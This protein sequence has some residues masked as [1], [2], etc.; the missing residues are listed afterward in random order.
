MRP[1]IEMKKGRMQSA[2]EYL[3]VYGIAFLIIA[4]AVILLYRVFASP[5]SKIYNS[6]SFAAGVTCSEIVFGTNSLTSNS[7]PDR[8]A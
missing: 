8:P 4:I 5:A 3:I 6:C 2:M 7:A 1:A